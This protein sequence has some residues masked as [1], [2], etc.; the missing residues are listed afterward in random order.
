VPR[1]ELDGAEYRAAKV[2]LQDLLVER[3]TA[4]ARREKFDAADVRLLFKNAAPTMRALVLGLMLGD[5][6][7]ADGPTIV[8]AIENSLS[9][10]EQYQGLNLALGNWSRLAAPY[11]SA[12]IAAINDRPEIM[13]ANSRRAVAEKILALPPR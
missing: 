3:S 9:A 11:R 8:D 5:S 10:N 7:L 12:V 13:A 6:S 4:I 1:E 2:H